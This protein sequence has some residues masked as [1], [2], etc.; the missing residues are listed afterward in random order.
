MPEC[1]GTRTH[2]IGSA[3]GGLNVHLTRA[4]AKCVARATAPSRPFPC[5]THFFTREYRDM[6]LQYACCVSFHQC[7]HLSL[8]SARFALPVQS[9]VVVACPL[10]AFY[11]DSFSSAICRESHFRFILYVQRLPIGQPSGRGIPVLLCR[12]IVGHGLVRPQPLEVSRPIAGLA[13]CG[14]CR[15]FT[16]K[17][18]RI[19]ETVQNG[20]CS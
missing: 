6:L 7:T 9:I 8:Y 17:E 13:G 11:L 20:N 18:S 2:P 4:P 19:Y 16:T 12:H 14:R 1:M 5:S 15:D 3:E 10:P